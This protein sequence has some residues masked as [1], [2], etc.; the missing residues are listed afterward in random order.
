MGLCWCTGACI[1]CKRPFT[2][3]PVR[4]PSTSLLNGT[5]QP[6]CSYCIE[7]VN[8]RRKEAGL[9]LWPIPDDAYQPCDESEL[10]L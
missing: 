3:N 9:P 1:V 2:F 7:I 5:R 4:V 8:A 6:I 10:Y